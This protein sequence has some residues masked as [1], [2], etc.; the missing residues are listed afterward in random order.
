MIFIPLIES[1]C[2]RQADKGSVFHSTQSGNCP[3]NFKISAKLNELNLISPDNLITIL[4][5]VVVEL[6]DTHSS[7]LE[8]VRLAQKCV[9]CPLNG[10]L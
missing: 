10:S 6:A 1:I 3:T 7:S 8:L 9:P 4:T 2:G 5:P